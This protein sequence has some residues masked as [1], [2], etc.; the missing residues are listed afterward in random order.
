MTQRGRF[1]CDPY[2]SQPT[3]EQLAKA[4]ATVSLALQGKLTPGKGFIGSPIEE[5]G[6]AH[7]RKMHRT[8]R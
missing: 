7:L 8:S 1:S 2:D 5:T 6:L 3:L 4:R